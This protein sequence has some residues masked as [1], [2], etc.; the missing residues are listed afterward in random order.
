MHAMFYIIGI[1]LMYIAFYII[2]NERSLLL[3]I[4]QK[5]KHILI[6]AIIFSNILFKQEMDKNAIHGMNYK[7]TYSILNFA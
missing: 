5:K 1:T 6:N 4:Y 7:F 3:I 2:F